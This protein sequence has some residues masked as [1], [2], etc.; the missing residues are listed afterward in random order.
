MPMPMPALAMAGG[1]QLGAGEAGTA[2]AIGGPGP[3]TGLGAG[4][5]MMAKHEG[6]GG[7]S[8]G[9]SGEAA[10]RAREELQ[11]IQQKLKEGGLSGKEK[12]RLRSRKNELQSQLG[13]G[14]DEAAIPE[15]T[16]IP[17]AP[18]RTGF[19]RRA[20]GLT[21]KEAATDIPGW[22]RTWPDA[23][24]YVNESGVDF[25]TRMMD[26]QYGSGRWSREGNQ[27]TEFSQLKK[28]GDRAFE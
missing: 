8:S 7:G 23:R 20:A 17:E 11:Q 16:P 19:K 6:E 15:V 1:G 13:T 24:P 9:L 25:A 3:M 27:A 4:G 10:A 26:K 18:P 14:A 22:A 2:V 28:F 12:S 5:S 21:G